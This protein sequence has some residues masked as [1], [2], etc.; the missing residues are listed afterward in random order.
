MRCI[1]KLAQACAVGLIVVAVLAALGIPRHPSLLTDER[2]RRIVG[3]SNQFHIQTLQTCDEEA[4]VAVGKGLPGQLVVAY[5]ECPANNNNAVC[6]QCSPQDGNP[7]NMIVQ[8]GGGSGAIKFG[9]SLSCGN[10][11]WGNCANMNGVE[12]CNGLAPVNITCANA[13]EYW[14]Q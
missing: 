1:L 5:D 11:F 13:V 2:L 12:S 6:V 9:Q 8:Q 7:T 4:A 3:T 14:N 10:L